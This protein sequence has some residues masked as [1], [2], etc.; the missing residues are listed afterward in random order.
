MP[1]TP[2]P[3][4][5]G[6]EAYMSRSE[7]FGFRADIDVGFLGSLKPRASARLIALTHTELFRS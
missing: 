5:E 3:P 6:S 4:V 1:T 2:M 7:L